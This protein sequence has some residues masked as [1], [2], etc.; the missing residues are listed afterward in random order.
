MPIIRISS[1]ALSDNLDM[2][3][4]MQALSSGIS[5]DVRIEQAQLSLSWQIIEANHYI[6]KGEVAETQPS[7]THPI[8]VELL[9]PEVLSKDLSEKIMHS[10]AHRLG[11]ELNFPVSNIFIYERQLASQQ[12]FE[13]GMIA[14]WA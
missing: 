1:L 4:V 2:K 10:L 11:K 14:N 8:L 9:I 13:E 3:Q 5:R 6:A 12:V 7:H